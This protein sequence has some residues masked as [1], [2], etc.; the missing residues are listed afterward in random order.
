M[1]KLISFVMVMC[2]AMPN[3]VSAQD[4]VND[5]KFYVGGSLGFTQNFVDGESTTNTFELKPELGYNI[6]DKLSL[7]L[8]LGF[9]R[10]KVKDVDGDTKTFSINPYLRYAFYRNGKV[11]IFCDGGFSYDHRNHYDAK[12]NGFEIGLYPGVSYQISSKFSLVA[13]LGSL[14]YQYNKPE[15]DGAVSASSFGLNLWNGTAFGLYFH[16]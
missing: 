8:A 14:A 15:G 9:S 6:N 3:L 4:E 5:N 12:S 1:K 13:H 2:F 10:D 11:S 16:F 7:G